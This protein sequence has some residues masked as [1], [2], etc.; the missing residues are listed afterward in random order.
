MQTQEDLD[1]VCGI[2]I[3][4]TPRY[5]NKEAQ[6]QCRNAIWAAK[7]KVNER[8]KRILEE[9]SSQ[10]MTEEIKRR[11]KTNS[12]FYV[13]AEVM[14]LEGEEYNSEEIFVL[15][16][17]VMGDREEL[18]DKM[19]NLL[20][21][22]SVGNTVCKTLHPLLVKYIEETIPKMKIEWE[23]EDTEYGE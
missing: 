10:I 14:G 20:Q 13:R 5:P 1:L 15:E 16:L 21:E 23:L 17:D 6:N 4:V 12:N 7:E 8:L 22:G 2:T 3:D 18:Y 19:S 11:I 9:Q